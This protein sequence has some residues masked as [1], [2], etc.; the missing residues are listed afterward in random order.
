LIFLYVEFLEIAQGD[1][2]KAKTLLGTKVDF[3]SQAQGN[4][5]QLLTRGGSHGPSMAPGEDLEVAVIGRA[6]F[7]LDILFRSRPT[8]LVN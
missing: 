7:F 2:D 1:T 8:K 4:F 6:T 5:C 3:L